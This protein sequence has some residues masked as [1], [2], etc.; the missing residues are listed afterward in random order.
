MS[1]F[2]A[3]LDDSIE[4]E[5][6]G[7]ETNP[8]AELLQQPVVAKAKRRI[9]AFSREY[10]AWLKEMAKPRKAVAVLKAV[11]TEREAKEQCPCCGGTGEYVGAAY[12]TRCARCKGKG[13]LFPAD[14]MAHRKWEDARAAGLP[15]VR[16]D[17]GA[18]FNFA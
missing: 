16:D 12:T 13:Y 2:D 7:E 4:N 18:A 1:D 8:L 9:V 5:A 11:L 10:F 6:F 14:I 15:R 17:F 3:L